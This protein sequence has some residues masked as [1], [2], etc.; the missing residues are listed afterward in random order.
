LVRVLDWQA[1]VAGSVRATGRWFG[2]SHVRDVHLA[3]WI[4][5]LAEPAAGEDVA[6]G[7]AVGEDVPKVTD[8]AGREAVIGLAAEALATLGL[9]PV[10]G[11]VLGEVEVVV[12]RAERK[13]EAARSGPGQCAPEVLDLQRVDAVV[14]VGP[15][16]TAIGCLADAAVTSRV[17]R[18]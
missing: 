14:R 18:T 5:W 10:R 17:H 4:R 12:L 7:T 3:A 6:A 16:G 1:H 9:G 2:P 8:A 13:V 15:R 11:A